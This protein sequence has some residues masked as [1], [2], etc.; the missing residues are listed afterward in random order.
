VAIV[1]IQRADW[2]LEADRAKR[3][4]PQILADQCRVHSLRVQSL[5]DGQ[6]K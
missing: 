5:R 6:Y 1:K 2:T 4:L 3:N